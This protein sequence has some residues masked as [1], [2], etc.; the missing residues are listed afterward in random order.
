MICDAPEQVATGRYSKSHKSLA[1]QGGCTSVGGLMAARGL[2]QLDVLWADLHGAEVQALRGA[3]LDRIGH[4]HIG[5]HGRKM[6]NASLHLLRAALH[7]VEYHIP[8][9]DPY[10][11]TNDGYIHAVH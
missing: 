7:L 4:V 11:A 5:T 2:T 8:P 3:P 1:A 9:H 6:H 10:F